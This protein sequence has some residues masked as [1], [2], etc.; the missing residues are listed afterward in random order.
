[1]LWWV[2]NWV[3]GLP[4]FGIG[5]HS[6]YLRKYPTNTG[7]ARIQTMTCMF[8]PQCPNH[9]T[10][11]VLYQPSPF[12][13][14]VA[15]KPITSR[16]EPVTPP[17]IWRRH[18]FTACGF[19]ALKQNYHFNY[20]MTALLVTD[21]LHGH[22]YASRRVNWYT[23]NIIGHSLCCVHYQFCIQWWKKWKYATKPLNISLLTR[24][25]VSEW[26]VLLTLSSSEG[27]KSS[28]HHPTNM[29]MSWIRTNELDICQSM[30]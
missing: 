30:L 15:N 24:Q 28:G 17:I 1:M 25:I 22:I 6:T 20:K 8:A 23:V 11:W 19:I 16:I 13:V 9:C 5:H 14:T 7:M 21:M 4:R 10:I 18:Q 29:G 12:A 26:A 2:S 27:K 3:I